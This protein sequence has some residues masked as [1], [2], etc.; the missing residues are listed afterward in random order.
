[1]CSGSL[2]PFPFCFDEADEEKIQALNDTKIEDRRNIYPFE[3]QIRPEWVFLQSAGRV[4]Y[5]SLLEKDGPTLYQP[6]KFTLR[7]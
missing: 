1:M 2:V 3:R 5:I 4:L 7:R 6:P